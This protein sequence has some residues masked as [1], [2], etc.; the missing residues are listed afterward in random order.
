MQDGPHRRFGRNLDETCFRWRKLLENSATRADVRDLVVLGLAM[1]QRPWDL[2]TVGSCYPSN[3]HYSA[4]LEVR[5]RHIIK[6]DKE[7]GE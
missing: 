2:A 4:A 5:C 1:E 7:L 6:T 3:G